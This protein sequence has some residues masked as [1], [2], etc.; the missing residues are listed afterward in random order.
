MRLLR[1][2]LAGRPAYG[3]LREEVVEVLEGPPYDGL[4]RSGE[5]VP[6]AEVR[7]LAPTVPVNVFGMGANSGQDIP[8]TPVAFLKPA[9]SVVGPGAPVEVPPGIGRVDFE[10]ELAVVVGRRA[11]NLRERD[12][13]DHV[14]GYT[15]GNDVTARGLQRAEPT[16]YRAKGFD[17]F[18]PLGPWV[19]TELDPHDLWLRG[20]VSGM[21][22]Q[23]TR[24]SALA[25]QVEE[26][27]AFL[28]SALTLQPGDVVLTGAPGTTGPI[29]PG[30]T[31]DVEVEGVGRLSNPVVAGPGSWEVRDGG[32]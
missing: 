6:L 9:S 7:L 31:V 16:S 24:T 5:V 14:L 4:R 28:S 12:V 3:I 26:I 18:T 15:C 32:A 1:V 21:L 22:V 2:E 23:D 25:R 29:G 19:E 8:A 11:R 13:L 17:T 30:D 10:G 27:V 20:W